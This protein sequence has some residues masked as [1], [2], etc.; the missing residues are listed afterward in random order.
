M[1]YV[2]SYINTPEGS[3]FVSSGRAYMLNMDIITSGKIGYQNPWNAEETESVFSTSGVGSTWILVL[4]GVFISDWIGFFLAISVFL[5]AAGISIYIFSGRNET[6]IYSTL[7]YMISAGLGGAILAAL[8]IFYPDILGKGIQAGF[9]YGGFKNDEAIYYSLSPFLGVVSLY[10]LSK[11]RLLASSI[12]LG[13]CIFVYPNYGFMFFLAHI[14]YVL[15]F[16]IRKRTAIKFLPV[17]AAFASPWVFTFLSGGEYIR[18]YRASISTG[19]GEFLPTLVIS[20]A[21][22][23]FFSF[24]YLRGKLSLPGWKIFAVAFLAAFVVSTIGQA[25]IHG[26]A[27][28]AGIKKSL[29]L[30]IKIERHLSLVMQSFFI[31]YMAA[32]IY[33][34]FRK[35][36]NFFAGNIDGFLFLWAY[37]VVFISMFPQDLAVWIAGR[38]IGVSTIPLSILAAKGVI[39]F[40]R[41]H[42]IKSACTVFAVILLSMPTILVYNYYMVSPEINHD[43]YIEKEK[44]DSIMPLRDMEDGVVFIDVGRSDLVPYYIGKKSVLS[45]NGYVIRDYWEKVENYK[46]LP[47]MGENDRLGVLRKYNVRYLVIGNGVEVVW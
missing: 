5:F 6:G 31:V 10:F 17:V 28:L 3:Y 36:R 35:N 18:V 12:F 44:F 20:M 8:G 16:G 33:A 32:F 34:I 1:R 29:N 40:S 13:L 19:I 25:G 23:F 42:N 15:S 4:L 9:G 26:D 30:D 21:F 39:R 46:K 7:I 2:Y 11:K 41:S 37:A 38:T 22:L 14:I 43:L 45:G 24:Y 27:E 47:E